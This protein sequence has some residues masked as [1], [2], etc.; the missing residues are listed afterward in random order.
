M[1]RTI[2][3][4]MYNEHGRNLFNLSSSD[5]GQEAPP[6]KNKAKIIN[7]KIPYEKRKERD[8]CSYL[9]HHTSFK[10]DT[11]LFFYL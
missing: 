3:S 1:C 8:I 11:Y 5:P 7:N 9:I 10:R 2:T 4:I 6:I